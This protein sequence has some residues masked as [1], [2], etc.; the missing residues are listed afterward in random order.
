MTQTQECRGFE[1]PDFRNSFFEKRQAGERT[2]AGPQA[3]AR[4]GSRGSI[5]FY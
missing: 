3:D 1:I 5:S 4:S 2:F